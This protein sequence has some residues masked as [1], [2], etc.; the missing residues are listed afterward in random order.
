MENAKPG[1]ERE[2]MKEWEAVPLQYINNINIFV[3]S[4][5]L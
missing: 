1:I 2:H 3:K 5:K 4:T